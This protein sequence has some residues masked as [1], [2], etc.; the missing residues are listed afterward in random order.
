[1]HIGFGTLPVDRR[2]IQRALPGHLQKLTSLGLRLLRLVSAKA[3]PPDQSRQHNDHGHAEQP[4]APRQRYR[5]FGRRRRVAIGS[6]LRLEV[7]DVDVDFGV[8]VLGHFRIHRYLHA[9]LRSSW[10]L[11]SR[12]IAVSC[13]AAATSFAMICP[14][15]R[16]APD[17][18]WCTDARPARYRCRWPGC[19]RRRPPAV[20]REPVGPVLL[21]AGTRAAVAGCLGRCRWRWGRLSSSSRR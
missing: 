4:R 2:Q 6:G 19:T 21:A 13:P 3:Q 10:W 17:R 9:V 1:M 5:L 14:S 8:V 7:L 20:V 18:F 11:G 16:F 12:A 15:A